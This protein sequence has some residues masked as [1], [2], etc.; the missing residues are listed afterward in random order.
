[1]RTLDLA[2]IAIGWLVLSAGA[3]VPT[4]AKASAEATATETSRMER[5]VREAEAKLKRMREELAA[6]ESAPP[7]PRRAAPTG[8]DADRPGKT[9]LPK[10]AVKDIPARPIASAE[11]PFANALYALGKYQ[12]AQAIYRRIA[13]GAN[14]EE[15]RAWARFQIGNCARKTNDMVA[16]LAAYDELLAKSPN[17]LWAQEA[18]W[19]SGQVKW[20]LLWRETTKRKA[21]LETRN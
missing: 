7:P 3:A 14:V 5:S 2:A 20:R 10:R 8:P 21:D 9:P 4:D 16:A 6:I 17:T 19:W 18:A 1:M 11:E 13:A 12:R 15:K